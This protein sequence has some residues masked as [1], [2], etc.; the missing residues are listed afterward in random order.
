MTVLSDWFAY[1]IQGLVFEPPSKP[2]YGEHQASYVYTSAGLRVATMLLRPVTAEVRQAP[3]EDLVDL[4]FGVPGADAGPKE[5]LAPARPLL[6]YSHGNAEDLGTAYD[7]LQWLATSL[8]CDVLA[9]DYVGYGHSSEG[10]MSEAN[11]YLA[12]EA[13]YEH[14]A[15]RLAPPALN[16]A[17]VLMGRSLGC[18][19]STRL[20]RTLSER[21]HETGARLFQGLVLVSPLASG[22]RVLFGVGSSPSALFGMLDRLFC[23]VAQEIQDVTQPVFIV[24]GLQDDTIDVR[25]SYEIQGHVPVRYLYPPLYLDAGHNDVFELHASRMVTQLRGFMCHCRVW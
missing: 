24:H 22:F 4:R 11:M 8:E 13:V 10:L 25:N 2:G 3:V 15:R 17:L 1:A 5:T 14:A 9:Y 7:H 6:L 18:T 23:P 16:S 19:A 21:Q 12:I 20:A